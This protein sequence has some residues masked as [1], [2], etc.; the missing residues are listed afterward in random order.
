M[1]KSFSEQFPDCSLA[2]ILEQFSP[3]STLGTFLAET[4]LYSPVNMRMQ[5]LIFLLRNQLLVQIHTYLYL[6]PPPSTH[7][8]SGCDQSVLSPR[9]RT[10]IG[11]ARDLAPEIRDYLLDLCRFLFTISNPFQNNFLSQA[12]S[13]GVEESEVFW[14]LN[15][16][17]RYLFHNHN[18]CQ[19]VASIF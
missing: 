11:N 4:A 13:S 12:I 8:L 19:I 6:L 2:E 9:I 1:A 14:L 10:V 16:F 15:S 7:R 18:Y 5:M 17:I 3:P